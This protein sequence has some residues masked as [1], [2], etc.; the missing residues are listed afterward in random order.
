MGSDESKTSDE[1]Q[2]HLELAQALL[3]E[4]VT[5]LSAF[6]RALERAGYPFRSPINIASIIA[7]TDALCF[8]DEQ[9]S[10]RNLQP[11][12]RQRT[13]SINLPL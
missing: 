12:V 1:L 5:G 13:D 3:M 10:K 7:R 8:P 6:Q 11:Q 4:A 2:A 9:K